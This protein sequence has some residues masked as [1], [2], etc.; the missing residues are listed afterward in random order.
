MR[1]VKMILALL[2][3]VS[4]AAPASA[5]IVYSFGAAPA[6]TRLVENFDGRTLG[7]NSGT[8]SM[9]G[10]QF[11]LSNSH[12][13]QGTTGTYAKPYLD[14][15]QYASINAGGRI[16]FNLTNPSNYFGLYWGS[17]DTYNSLSFY[18]GS[19]LLGTIGGASIISAAGLQAGNQGAFGSVFA[20]F[21]SSIGFD[22][23]VAYSSGIAF[24]FDDVRLSAVPLPAALPMF[25]GLMGAMGLAARRRKRAA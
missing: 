1:N 3:M 9:P 5:S 24:E 8:F 15:T 7:T 25:G 21:A 4:V 20:N 6:N 12:I 16:T 2:A 19:T 10:G 13:V 17:V 14:N 18:S 22:K 23:V 11:S